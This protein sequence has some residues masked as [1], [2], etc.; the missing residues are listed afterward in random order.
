MALAKLR[1]RWMPRSPTFASAREVGVGGDGTWVGSNSRPLSTTRATSIAP[2]R[3]TS[4]MISRC[5]SLVPPYMMTLATASSR[6][7]W[8]ANDTSVE[9]PWRPQPSIHA[10]S[11]FN[12]ARSLCKRRRLDSTL[13]IGLRCQSRRRSG[14]GLMDRNQGIHSG[15][16]EDLGNV[17]V[18]A[19]D[20]QPSAF[21]RDDLGTDQ[22]HADGIGRQKVHGRK[23]DHD[24]A[25]LRD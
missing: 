15:A 25:L 21:T 10:A 9:T 11:R 8:T 17:V 23:I 7:S 19:E 20:H 16:L 3:S 1:M 13:D 22:Q 24:P 2:L 18:G 5:S 4:T 14:F 6:Q 12:S